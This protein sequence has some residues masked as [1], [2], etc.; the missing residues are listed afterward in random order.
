MTDCRTTAPPAS[1]PSRSCCGLDP[2]PPVEDL[3]R[4]VFVLSGRGDDVTT[5]ALAGLLG[6]QPPTVSSM[7]KRLAE[8]GLVERT[9]D[10]RSRLTEHGAAHARH[11]V[12]RHRLVETLLVE[13]LGMPPEAVHPEADAL[14]HAVSETLLERI[15]AHLGRP[16]RDP[17]GDPIP[18]DG[19][20]PES[21]PHAD[22]DADPEAE[23]GLRLD[24]AADRSRF[25][26]CRVHD[27]DGA[28]LRH[29]AALGIG[30]G[31]ELDVLT[32]G[33]FDGPLF[34]RVAGQEHALSERLARLVHGRPVPEVPAV[35]AGDRGPSDV[36]G[37]QP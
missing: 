4:I 33:P 29:L 16:V 12:R 8:H 35:P 2:S 22:P 30:P 31:T 7:L 36:G 14:E 3:L 10:H 15:D 23:W 25:A 17:H 37:E 18:R 26:V 11:V 6:V 27:W 20:R 5:S 34:V 24:G 28:A 13:V 21:D 32:R 19:G 1:R 9:G